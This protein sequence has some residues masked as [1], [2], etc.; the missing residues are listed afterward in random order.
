MQIE[1][2]IKT[3]LPLLNEKQK[4][5]FLASMSKEYGVRNVC[6]VSGCSAHT[7]IKGKRELEN[8]ETVGRIRSKGGG[9]KKLE[10]EYPELLNWI[11]KI[12]ADETYGNPENPLVWTTKS[13]RKIQETILSKHEVYLS[14]KSVGTLLKKLGYSL[15]SN[16][17]ML[18]MGESHP[19]RNAQ[20]EYI[21]TTVRDFINESQ[22]VISVDTKKKEL[23]GNYANKG[24]EYR[25]S[26]TPRQVYDH[27]FPVG[28]M[29]K[30]SPYG[31]YVMNDNTAFVNL[32]TSRDTGEFA[33]ASICRWWDIIGKHSFPNAH[34]LLINCDC[35]GSNGYKRRLWKTELQQ[36]ANRSGLTLYITHFPPGTSKWNKVEHKLFCYISKNWAGKPLVDIETVVN[37]ISNTTTKTDLKVV[38]VPD[39]TEYLTGIKVSDELFEAVNISKIPPHGEWNYIISPFEKTRE[40]ATMKTMLTQRCVLSPLED[41]DFDELIP[42]FTNAEVRKYL[43]GVRPTDEVLT[44]LRNSIQ[45][46]REYPFTLR[47][48]N[49]NA[50]IGY[51]VIAPHHNP[52]DMELSYMF[53][54]KFW[55][56]GYASETVKA[57]IDFCRSELNL[58]RIVAETQAAN[59]RSCALLEKLGFRQED[60]FI[61]FNA[62]QSLYVFE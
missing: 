30:V 19:D 3:M 38:C 59:I 58:T 25:K 16:R 4:R 43:G 28:K 10:E 13:L 17:K 14:F 31:I 1:E 55:G 26:K 41:A 60:S 35:G 44:G 62:K 5:L 40:Q 61:R 34:K 29:L 11:E 15:Q 52:E 51:A 23:I 54:P 12:V 9:R 47:L 50:L 22:P 7:V 6:R 56:C 18:Q 37:L 32:G 33:V 8:G 24:Q 53:L 48:S 21:N 42:L 2:H 36:F 27:D 39:N 45:S 20:F 57:L 46:A 49:E